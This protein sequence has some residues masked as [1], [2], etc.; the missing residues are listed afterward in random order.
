MVSTIYILYLQLDVCNCPLG[1]VKR[2]A[3]H[4]VHQVGLGLGVVKR[5]C[6]ILYRGLLQSGPPPG[7][8]FLILAWILG[9]YTLCF[10]GWRWVK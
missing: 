10:G 2:P 1:Q 5:Y 7:V 6:R 4:N 3:L 8:Q 9:G